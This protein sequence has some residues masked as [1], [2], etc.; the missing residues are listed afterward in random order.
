MDVESVLDVCYQK[1][2]QTFHDIKMD[3]KEVGSGVWA[4]FMWL[5]VG[6]GVWSMGWIYVVDDRD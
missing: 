1:G 6:T 3:L 4:R 5:M 2:L